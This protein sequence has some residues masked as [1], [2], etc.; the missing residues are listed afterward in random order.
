[1]SDFLPKTSK[2]VVSDNF[3]TKHS[4][5]DSHDKLSGIFERD[6]T[7]IQSSAEKTKEVKHSLLVGRRY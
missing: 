1:M 2:I 6:D 3:I 5:D 4:N 7:D